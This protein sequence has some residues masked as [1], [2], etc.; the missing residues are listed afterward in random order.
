MDSLRDWEEALGGGDPDLMSQTPQDL[1][2]VRAGQVGP[3]APSYVRTD[4]TSLSKSSDPNTART[5]S[6][7]LKQQE[8]YDNSPDFQRSP[9]LP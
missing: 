1:A 5:A 4:L 7:A 2:R 8:F 6:D 9:N 3:N